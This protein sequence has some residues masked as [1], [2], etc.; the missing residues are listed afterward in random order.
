MIYRQDDPAPLRRQKPVIDTNPARARAQDAWRRG[1]AGDLAWLERAHRLAPA[2]QNLRFQLATRRLQAGDAAGAAKLFEAMAARF[3]VRE[4]WSGLAASCRA[5]GRN[6]EARAAVHAALSGFAADPGLVRLANQIAGAQGWCGLRADG[7]LLTSRADPPDLLLDGAPIRTTRAVDGSVPL[8]AGAREAATLDVSVAGAKLLGSPI[9]LAAIRRVQGFAAR[10]GDTI[11][12]YA[13]Q[14]ASPDAD[15]ELRLL[16][17]AG[18]ELARFIAD[19]PGGSDGAVPLARPRIFR[20]QAPP[21]TTIR[22]IGPD[23]RDLLGSPLPP[24]IP[25]ALPPA[26]PGLARTPDA[27]LAADVIVPV[28]RGAAETLACIAAVLAT[29]AAPDRLVAVNDASPEPALLAALTCLAEAGR[30]TL[31]HT[32]PDAR[33]FPAAINAGLRHAAG[34]HAVLLNSDTLVAP[35]WLDTL[36]HAACSAADIGT[37]TPLSNEASIF[38]YPE[39]SG[40]NPA[41]DLAGT[42]ALAAL[43]AQA[44]AGRL[45]D[46]PTAHGFCMFV[47]ADCLAE[48]GLFDAATFAQGYGEEN[49]FSERARALGWRHVAVPA[50]FVAHLGGISFGG[51]RDDLLARNLAILEAR[52][53]AYRARVAAFV[54]SDAL[55]PARRRLDAARWLARPPEGGAVL[56]ITHNMG[57]GTARIVAERADAI[58]AQGHTPVVLRAADGLCEVGDDAGG[59]PN[60]A[61]AL[62]RELGP[63]AR[64]LRPGRPV[65]AELHHL[66]GHDHSVMRLLATLAIPY[67]VWVHDYGWFCARLSFVTGEGRFCGEADTRQCALCLAEWGRGIDDP[68]SPA[69]LRRRSAADFR[70][71]AAVIVPSDDVARRVARHVPG[72][73]PSVRAWETD[74]PHAA[75]APL[76]RRGTLRVAVVG[77]IGVEKG[78]GVLLACARDAAARR[79]DLSFTVIGYTSDDD[80]LLATGRAFITG[81]F[82]RGEA[83]A[84]IRAQGAHLAFLPSV[85]PETWCYAL[86]D[87]WQAGLPAAVFDIGTPAER[88]RAHG[89]GWV[90]P[91]GL[92]PDR[93][94]DAFLRLAAAG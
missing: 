86:T 68:V 43:A 9:N 45:V 62:P 61:Y 76:P 79:L 49:D 94:N 48:T 64:L 47:R 92:P 15:P 35:G 91:L 46:V 78:L 85:W 80:A 69:S 53:P 59:F 77:A 84:L 29:I 3:A 34:R 87:I 17:A 33:G 83:A 65:R 72:L 40:G 89:R 24:A 55:A 8:P 70:R 21:G 57:G 20:W 30:L 60:L 52:H 5:L 6:A 56:L 82:T 51:A 25:D 13:W 2:D 10:E 26:Q 75:P 7:A 14:P 66:L 11:T 18:A 90:L 74:P 93:L 12:G 88:V 81:E 22:V 28:H 16:T 23:G 32:E 19:A 50:V 37:A 38:S 44:N 39:A 31:L 71:A 27:N 41:P 58:R 4:C 63:L 36:R 1:E 54:A 67:D 73:V 42:T